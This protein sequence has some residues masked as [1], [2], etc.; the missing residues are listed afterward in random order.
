MKIVEIGIVPDIEGASM[1]KR[2]FPQST[3]MVLPMGPSNIVATDDVDVIVHGGDIVEVVK[4]LGPFGLIVDR[5]DALQRDVLA[6]FQM[7]WPGLGSGGVYALENVS[8]SYWLEYTSGDA[9]STSTTLSKM[10]VDVVNMHGDRIPESE[11][12]PIGARRSDILS[13]HT[14]HRS[15]VAAMTCTNGLTLLHKS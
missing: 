9:E 5:G 14:E 2:W 3:V 1:W 10:M 11:G 12:L 15:D 6:F 4:V 8:A 13:Q 7:L